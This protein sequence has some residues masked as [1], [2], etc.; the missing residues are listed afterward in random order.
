MPDI[1][2]LIIV[3]AAVGTA[4]FVALR[5][6]WRAIRGRGTCASCPDASGCKLRQIRDRQN[7]GRRNGGRKSCCQ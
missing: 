6:L 5:G 1:V 7:C 3:G 4:V 2:Q